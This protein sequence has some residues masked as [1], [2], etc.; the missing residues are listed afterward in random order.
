MSRNAIAEL[1]PAARE[2]WPSQLQSSGKGGHSVQFYRSREFLAR[3][4]GEFI[5]E[6]IHRG[7]A[8][9]LL[10]T[11][12][13]AAAIRAALAERGVDPQ[14]ASES[15]RLTILGAFET[16]ES[17]LVEGEPDARRFHSLLGGTI[18][19][20]GMGR[21]GVRVFGEMVALL[22][23]NGRR[24]CTVRLEQL[25]NQLAATH[26]FSLLCAYDQAGFV[27]HAHTEGFHAICESH[28]HVLP[29]ERVHLEEKPAESHRAL[30]QLIHQSDVIETEL[31]KR[32]EMERALV[33]SQNLKKLIV[34][35]SHDW[36]QLLDLE[37]K[38][39]F[40]NEGGIKAA[41]SACL[42][43]VRG[44]SW[45]DVWP[46]SERANAR[47][48][49]ARARSGEIGSFTGKL[50][51]GDEFRW[52]DVVLSP[53]CEK[54]IVKQ[55]LVVSRDVTD[56]IKLE[57]ELRE[58][59]R[60]RD[61]FLSLASHELKTP[62]TS[63]LLQ[64]ALRRRQA[65]TASPETARRNEIIKSQVLRLARVIDDMLDTS[66]ITHGTM[67]LDR[68]ETDLGV[69]VQE[70]LERFEDRLL[71][72]GRQLLVKL[73]NGVV[74]QWDRFRLDQV[75]TNL[76]INT[77]KHGSDSEVVEVR[78]CRAG[79]RAIVTVRDEGPGIPRA[80]LERIFQ[81]FERGGPASKASGLGLG[82]FL[83][84]EIVEA[85][86]GSIWAES[87]GGRGAVFTVSLPL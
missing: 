21:K 1:L 46:D 35:S 20:I 5:A 42:E 23:N 58:A 67:R 66:R 65:E 34:D 78:L 26:E 47:A 25:W 57:L 4:V 36:I 14:F 41:G 38:I 70:T 76:F 10:V 40:V 52:W 3:A 32:R 61:E 50:S 55:I 17:I 48:A 7:E 80:S 79:N 85:H 8:A 18:E 12:E 51:F 27:E 9:L 60:T 37:G 69:L 54:G 15:G 77:L 82:L 6:G 24:Q 75:F 33:A 84:R 86:G 30:A 29:P 64:L 63:I 11:P 83:C 49:F 31:R 43:E 56:R 45:I 2:L 16:L 81:K 44:H 39:V 13:N 53:I 19:K 22:W 87:E 71:A 73:E 74:A 68:E 62:V 72:N 59:I 28:S